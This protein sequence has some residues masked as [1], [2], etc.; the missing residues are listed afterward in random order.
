MKGPSEKTKGSGIKP[1]CYTIVRALILATCVLVFFSGCGA[2]DK[3]DKKAGKKDDSD[4]KKADDKKAEAPAGTTAFEG[5]TFE[6]SGIVSVPGTNEVLIID[7]GKPDEV[8]WMK[9]DSAGKQSGEIK[10]LPLGVEI[11]NPEAITFDGTHYWI[12]GSISRPN[13]DNKPGLARFT[14]D[15]ASQTISSSAISGLR[16]FL[17]EQ[18]PEL[19]TDG[20]RSG[21]DDGLNI[22]GITWDPNSNRVLLGLRSPLA[23]EDALLVPIALR[24]PKGPL[25]LENLT[26]GQPTA[27]RVP[28]GGF[29]VRDIGYDND[30]KSFWIIAGATETQKKTDFVLWKWSGAGPPEKVETLTED[31]KPEG[32]TRLKVDDRSFL[33]VVGDASVYLKL[34]M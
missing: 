20:A 33:L 27:I 16:K 32:V 24:D 6:A 23:G 9:V 7:D 15:P 18:V 21:T 12:V 26:V 17:I 2:Q 10:R 13:S 5:G 19:K 8:L 1:V 34:D 28:V 31:M 25:T 22:E 29:G 11:Q 14:F 30:S 4:K 3:A